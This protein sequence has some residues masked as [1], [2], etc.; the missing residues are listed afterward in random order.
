MFSMIVVIEQHNAHEHVGLIEAMFRLRARVFRNRL[1]WDVCVRDGME[2]DRYDD[3]GPVYI[4]YTDDDAKQVKGSLRLL[5]TTGP[6]LLAD[7][8]SDT[9]PDAVDLSAPSIWECTRF[10][11]DDRIGRDGRRED[12]LVASGTLI[13]ALGEVALAAGIQT[14]LGNFDPLMLRVYRRIACE[15]EI[16][17]CTRRYGRDVYLG[18][19]PVSELILNRVRARVESARALLS[20][21]ADRESWAA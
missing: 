12:A 11:L 21:A 9:L 19:F 4:L 20:D 7:I 5:P 13:A 6:T 1:K 8:F 2:R 14:I 16:L 17:G 18:S 10:C 3:E 15:V